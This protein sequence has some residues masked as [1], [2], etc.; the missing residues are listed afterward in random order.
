[1]R[2]KHRHRTWAN[3]R[4]RAWQQKKQR[5]KRKRQYAAAKVYALAVLL[6]IATFCAAFFWRSSRPPELASSVPSTQPTTSAYDVPFSRTERD[7]SSARSEA[8]TRAAQAD[9]YVTQAPSHRFLCNVSSIT[10]G[11]TL[12]CSDG[13]RVRLHAVAARESDETC[14]PGHPCPSA[15]GAAATAMLTQLAGGQTLRCE[16]TGTTYNRIAAICRNEQD[17]E[18]NCAMVNS[19]TAVVWPRYNAERAICR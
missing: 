5:Y 9:P 7:S 18:I 19:G 11:D 4:H 8:S 14:S 15:S 1:M 17:T 13:T 2:G 6:F 16:Q 3:A 10:D 12:R